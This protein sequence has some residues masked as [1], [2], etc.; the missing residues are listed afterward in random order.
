MCGAIRDFS[1]IVD[2]KFLVICLFLIEEKVNR[3]TLKRFFSVHSMRK[4]THS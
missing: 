4:G 2:I 1:V 3:V